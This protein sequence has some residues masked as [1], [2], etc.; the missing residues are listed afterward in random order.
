VLFFICFL[1][2]RH[3]EINIIVQPSSAQ[4]AAAWATAGTPRGGGRQNQAVPSCRA[5]GPSKPGGPAAITA[6][7]VTNYVSLMLLPT[8]QKQHCNYKLVR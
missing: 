7:Y 8:L 6:K 2:P 4:S 5:K 1:E 3:P